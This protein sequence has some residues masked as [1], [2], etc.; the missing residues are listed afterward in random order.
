MRHST[1]LPVGLYE[2]EYLL[3]ITNME[4]E[5]TRYKSFEKI[6]SRVRILKILEP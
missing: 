2:E 4:Q 1:S 5:H 3:F 6:K